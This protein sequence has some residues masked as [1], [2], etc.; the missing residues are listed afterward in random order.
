M[1]KIRCKFVCFSVTDRGNEKDV[2]MTPV[3]SGS[4]EN[5]SFWK[6]T[7]TGKLEFTCL[8]SNAKLV[9]GREYYLDLIAVRPKTE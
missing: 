4:D 2:V 9:P 7:P 5:V 3:M 8:N 6:Y 1:S